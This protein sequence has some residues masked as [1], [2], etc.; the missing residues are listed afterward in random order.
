MGTWRCNVK[1]LGPG[2]ARLLN[3]NIGP[4]LRNPRSGQR[5]GA[6]FWPRAAYSPY[7]INGA[8]T[9]RRM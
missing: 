3:P 7:A 9:L 4:S 5:A 8:Q 2:E 6:P 1:L